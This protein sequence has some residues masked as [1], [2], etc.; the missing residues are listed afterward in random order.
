MGDIKGPY[1]SALIAAL[2]FYC[3]CS[4]SRKSAAVD[5]FY[6]GAPL[7]GRRSSL[8]YTKFKEYFL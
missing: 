4:S 8:F 1:K 2:V 3:G 5:E 7:L 6:C